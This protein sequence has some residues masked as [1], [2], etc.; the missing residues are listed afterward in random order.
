M[1]TVPGR[2]GREDLF[3]LFSRMREGSMEAFDRFYGQAA[4]FVMGIAGKLL[5]GD[6]MEME[7][8]CHD[9]LLT[10][11]SQPE[12]YSPERGS[13]EAW[14]AVLTKSRCMDRLRKRQRIVLEQR[15]TPFEQR[16]LAWAGEAALPEQRV[17]AKM[18]GE[19]LRQAL[20][21]LDGVQRQ[22]LAEV[23][24]GDRTRKELADVWRVP[25]GTVKSRVRYGLNHLHKAM[26]R[27]GWSDGPRG[28]G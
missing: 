24:F 14:L 1:S 8:V 10:V 25:I 3:E 19:A 22:T 11:I 20:A 28:G 12:K 26:E 27:L 18:E 6:R 2:K 13:V 9:V 7:D 4:P 15:E 21:E 5:G 23:Y 16:R 17:L